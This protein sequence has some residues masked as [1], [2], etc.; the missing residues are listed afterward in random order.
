MKERLAPPQAF[1][2]ALKRVLPQRAET[3]IFPLLMV[4]H[5]GQFDLI[6]D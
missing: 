5:I 6:A 1:E 4:S 3:A 2:I